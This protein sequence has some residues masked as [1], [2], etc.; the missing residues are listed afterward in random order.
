M[1][2]NFLTFNFK[3]ILFLTVFFIFTVLSSYSQNTGTISGKISDI[4]DS[5]PINDVNIVL[6]PGTLGGITNTE[7]LYKI[8]GIKPGIYS[9][10]ITHLNYKSIEQEVE[11]V[12]NKSSTYNFKLEP[13]SKMLSPVII[14]GE[15][16]KKQPFAINRIDSK[17]F[18]E[19]A[20]RDIGDY[21]RSIPNV[22]AIRKG[23]ASLDPVIRGFKF[24]QLNIQ[25]DH[26]M[27]IEGGCPNRMDPTASHVEPEDID[28]IEVFKGPYALKYG[29]SL[30]GVV[31][32]NTIKPIPYNK[33]Q[34]HVK[35]LR[36]YESNW[37]GNKEYLRINGGDKRIF[38]DLSGTRKNY[39]DYE[40]GDGNKVFSSFN[41]YSYK[42][43]LS[44]IP[45]ENHLINLSYGEYH[46]K[47]V[48]YPALQMDEREDN[49]QLMSLDYKVINL[50]KNFKN[51][52]L[53][54]YRSSVEH[55]MDNYERSIS[56]T[57][58]TYV[59]VD[60]INIGGRLEGLLSF[61]KH[62]FI[63]GA[64]YENVVKDGTRTKNM[65]GMMPNTSG[66]YNIKVEK[67]WSNAQ[68]NNLGIFS[69]YNSVYGAY[70][71]MGV[72][73]IDFNSATSDDIIVK[74]PGG[75]NIY[76]YGSDS[77]ASDYV[78]ISGAVGI[79]R[80]INEDFSVSLALGRG[81]R[82]PDMLERYIMLLPVGYDNF[83]Y[84]GNPQLKPEVNNEI[85]LTVKYNNKKYGDVE[86][87][88]FYAYV[89]DFIMGER[90]PKSVQK[91]LTAN[92]LAVKKFV[93]TEDVT[94]KGFE[95]AWASPKEHKLTA[96]LSVAYTMATISKILKH[97]TDSTGA[98]II[99][100]KLLTNDTVSE[101]PPLEANVALN[102]KFF[103]D[104]FNAH[105]G[106][107][108]VSSQ[109]KVSEAMYE[110]ETDGFMLANL[111]LTYYHNRY[112][113]ATAGVNNLFDKAYYEHLN[114]RIVGSRTA[115]LY[116]P[117]RVFY[118]NLIVNI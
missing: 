69:E 49:T 11:I 61:N 6:K 45:I 96:S 113:S 101:I 10:K 67:L 36:G 112:L 110:P 47:D 12:S 68:I 29:P 95:F 71:L 116:E 5:N 23:G 32:I 78:N 91:P 93:N 106:L 60:P 56:D 34:I 86:F 58:A 50:T 17:Q 13:I 22:A 18:E 111:S 25:L 103:K 76:H 90:I 9:I 118:I 41:R 48:K 31:N 117:G 100:D 28:N 108:L 75:A 114:R 97:I 43:Q 4:T 42:A 63:V 46:A 109:K 64:D 37:N 82:N 21:L 66:S 54:I 87:N 16:E 51:L 57:V 89:T 39:G 20:V 3:K 62:N 26:G 40:D 81:V 84:V 1:K 83:D 38:F 53:K 99:G 65:I 33:F 94:L 55:L 102:Y 92:V 44:F 104:K 73:R 85:D 115:R 27:K 35:A 8:E 107:R 15:R 74:N 98:N 88:A 70:E 30:G 79:T 59:L 14:E 77:T 7:G 24:S 105:G 80:N 72:A 19:T 52:K 2:T